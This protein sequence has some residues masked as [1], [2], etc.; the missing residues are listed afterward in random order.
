MSQKVLGK[1][2]NKSC[3][4]KSWFITPLLTWAPLYKDDVNTRTV[5]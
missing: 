2:D 5:A 4:L 1:W 3:F